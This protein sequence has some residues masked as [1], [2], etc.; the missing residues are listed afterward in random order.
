LYIYWVAK[1]LTEITFNIKCYHT[2]Y[3]MYYAQH[4]YTTRK[5]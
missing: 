5:L 2:S 3:K 1:V 4:F